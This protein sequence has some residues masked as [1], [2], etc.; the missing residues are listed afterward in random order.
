MIKNYM[1][2][3]FTI[4][5]LVFNPVVLKKIFDQIFKNN[6]NYFVIEAIID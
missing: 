6:L 5:Q 3:E 1:N 4:W 2:D